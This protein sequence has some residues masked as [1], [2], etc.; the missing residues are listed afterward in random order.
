[1]AETCGNHIDVARRIMCIEEDVKELRDAVQ[2]IRLEHK[3]FDTIDLKID[4]VEKG[5]SNLREELTQII[6]VNTD[7]TWQ[8]IY[9]GVKVIIALVACIIILAGVKLTPE[10]MKLFT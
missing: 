1:M 9:K 2:D 8:L 4:N 6:S 5:F 10:I 3:N 7:R